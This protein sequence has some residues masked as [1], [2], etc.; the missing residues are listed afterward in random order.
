[1][2]RRGR[3]RDRMVVGFTTTFVISAYYQWSC[4]LES[5]SDEVY[6]MQHNVIKFDRDLQQVRGFLRTVTKVSSTNKTDR[7][8]ITEILLKMS[9]NTITLT[10]PLEHEIESK[11]FQTIVSQ[12]YV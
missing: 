5:C 12:F 6:L 3:D 11:M 2:G 9:L 1:M 8:H 4:K 7:L 10:P